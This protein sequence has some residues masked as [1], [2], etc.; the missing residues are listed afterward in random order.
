M[1]VPYEPQYSPA[2]N[3]MSKCRVEMDVMVSWLG[4]N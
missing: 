1:G 2:S 4:Y 3:G